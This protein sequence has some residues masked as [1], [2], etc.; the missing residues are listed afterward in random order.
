MHPWGN[1][2]LTALVLPKYVESAGFNWVLFYKDISEAV[3][4]TDAVSRVNTHPFKQQIDMDNF[5]RRIGI[6]VTGL[7][8]MLSMLNMRYSSHEARDFVDKLFKAKA[9]REIMTSREI[10]QKYG[11][12]PAL[13]GEGKMAA[14]MN[15]P[16]MKRLE[17]ETDKDDALA[18]TAFNTIG[19]CG[20]ISIMAGNC[21]SGIEPLFAREYTRET[22][23][24]SYAIE[25]DTAN[26]ETAHEISWQDRIAMQATIQKYIDS[27]IS[28]TINL[29]N[30]AMV[31]DIEDI[32]LEAWRAGL[33]GITVFRDGCKAGVLTTHTP[34]IPCAL[35]ERTLLDIE[36][37]ERHRVMYKGA[38]VYIIVSLDEDDLP[39][40]IFAKL[41]R[42]AG[43]N[44]R[45]F[46]DQELYNET[47][48]N[49]DSNCRLASKL[50]RYNVPLGE[51]I[52]QLSKASNSMV[53]APGLIA[54]V[55]NKYMVVMDSCPQCGG[56]EY[57][58]EGGCAICKECGFSNCG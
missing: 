31:K 32:Y 21:T 39:V 49:W 27:G 35:I 24:G 54:R 8:D 12:V 48:A 15:T 37:A 25:H 7:A 45:K 13:A 46:F 5:S 40:E 55:L 28:S 47:V 44:G 57:I 3:W 36:T 19:P 50:L 29:P 16:Y 18:H 30:A 38:K 9:Q 22:A 10:A 41:P 34:E 51:V 23:N 52:S 14:F 11:C 6:E 1:C 53:D 26:S 43:V 42:Q 58:H 56:S 4:F 20:S 33:K 2:L 17:I